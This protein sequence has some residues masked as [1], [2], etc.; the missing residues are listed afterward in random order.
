[1]S[2]QRTIHVEPYLVVVLAQPEFSPRGSSTVGGYRARFTISRKDRRPVREHRQTVVSNPLPYD[3]GP[4]ASS[5]A[6]LALG[7]AEALAMV[8][9]LTD[10]AIGV[11]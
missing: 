5:D 1:M 2:T 4:L 6:A 10:E 7:E 9:A 3:G 8:A 11:C